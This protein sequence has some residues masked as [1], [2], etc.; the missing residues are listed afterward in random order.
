MTN[1]P[2]CVI[3]KTANAKRSIYDPLGN[4]VGMKIRNATDAEGVFT[5][6]WFE[7]NAFGDVVDLVPF[8]SGVGEA[9]DLMR[10][11][12]K[13]DDFVDAI[14]DVHDTAR[15]IGNVGEAAKELHRPYIRKSVREVVESRASRNAAGK[16]L[17]AN[18]ETVIEGK[19]DLGHVT[20]HEFWREKKMAMEKG[21]TQKQFNDYMNN[22]DFYRIED[23]HLNRSHK[24]EMPK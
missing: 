14:D 8:V 11:A 21:W 15:A 5:H 24:F 16:F 12:T 7:T 17:D 3:I 9:T 6:Y 1:P 20:G 22:P 13:A 2:A 23:P 4:P 18:T 10:V 19:Y